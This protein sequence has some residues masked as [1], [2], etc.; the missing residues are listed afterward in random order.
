MAADPLF[1][2]AFPDL[3]ANARAWVQALRERHDPQA[4]LIEA[5]FTLLFG[6]SE[7][8]QADYLAHVAAVA[9][10]SAPI[11]LRCSR[12]QPWAG[13]GD[14]ELYLFLQP[15]EGREAITELHDRLC[16]GP[17]AT[18]LRPELPYLPHITLGRV[19]GR[20][21]AQALCDEMNA[22]SREFCGRLNTLTVVALRQQR[23]EPL[24]GFR[25]G[26]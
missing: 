3:D 25:L 14:A 16:R 7:V 5:H 6:V 2:V 24:A 18:Q 17:L 13:P 19:Q 11:D 4:A 8:S 15:D 9:R 22:Q 10:V 1:T 23:I 26:A 12:V 21:R 20:A